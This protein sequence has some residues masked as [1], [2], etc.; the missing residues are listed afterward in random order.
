M[1]KLMLAVAMAAVMAAPSFAAVQNVKV[2]GDIKTTHVV[3]RGFDLGA[4]A[5][6]DSAQNFVIGQTGLNVSADLT[7]N[8]ATSIRLVNET[9]WG[10]TSSSTANMVLDTANVT[11]K[12][13]LYAPL[14]V[15]IGRQNLAY[16]N[17]LIIGDGDSRGQVTEATD[18]TGGVNFD[19]IKAVLSYDPLTIDVF[20]AK[21]NSRESDGNDEQNDDTD[22]LG[23]NANYKFG[24]KMNTVVE[25]YTFAKYEAIA[26]G[27]P[28]LTTKDR[29][30]V[31]GLRV[32]T[33]PIEGLNVQ[34]E[35]AYQLGSKDLT[36]S[37][38]LGTENKYSA[39]A[40]QGMA[41]YALPV[42][43]DM[44]PVVSASYTYLSGDK[45]GNN[46]S[47]TEKAWQSMYENQN[48]GRIFDAIIGQSNLKIASLAFEVVPVQDI[49]T[50]LTWYNL[51][52]AVK[53]DE[54]TTYSL[55]VI[56]GS[57][58]T[59]ANINKSSKAIGNE[60]DLDVSYAYT[61]DV[62]FGVSAGVFMPG[63]FFTRDNKDNASQILSSVSV[64][65]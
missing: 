27:N 34:L 44:K 40:V 46:N 64:L 7:D 18:L 32:S 6:A 48:G 13:M 9:A 57:G 39:Y 51:T 3:R 10:E 60:L 54:G 45:I 25:G 22:L 41:S 1:K 35:G 61:E 11:L 16:G 31:P 50:K 12:E 42:M 30:Y 52:H 21:V 56:D 23:I 38:A 47:S 49:T 33:N 15:T 62:K 37:P 14:T 24:D 8:V 26:A 19:A 63:K 53:Y 55:G 2:G 43:Q 5:T 59:T 65:F 17:Q 36:A 20:A 28:T 58:A 29:L 4:I